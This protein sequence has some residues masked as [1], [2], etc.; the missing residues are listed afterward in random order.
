MR[1]W[2]KVVGALELQANRACFTEIINIVL[3]LMRSERCLR[4]Q[5]QKQQ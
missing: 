5:Q 2:N 3:K 1:F 4:P